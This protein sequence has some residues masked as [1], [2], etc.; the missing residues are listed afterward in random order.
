MP[1]KFNPFTGNLDIEGPVLTGSGTVSA[2]ADGTEQ[3]PGISFANDLDTGIYRPGANQLAISTGGTAR[4]FVDSSGNIKIGGT[5]PSSQNISLNAD[6]S[7]E[8]SGS[9]SIGGT[10]AANTIDEYE[11]GTFSPDLKV[12]TSNA[13]LTGN[14]ARGS[15]TRIGNI[16]H[17]QITLIIDST[18]V[19]G[20]TGGL[21]IT[22]LPFASP[23]NLYSLYNVGYVGIFNWA[24]D[25]RNGS[26][27][28][29]GTNSNNS[30]EISLYNGSRSN[31]QLDETA[32]DFVPGKNQIY[33]NM[34][35]RV[36]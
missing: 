15:Y 1:Y 32:L 12:G 13:G 4:L 33:V 10:A 14:N 17:I 27:T 31:G 9:V 3:V 2:A 35:Y 34:T 8:F 20:L 6:G 19:T 23:N 28:I 30:T 16:A 18:D 11:E 29:Y 7:T 21:S 24:T 25:Y 26:K 22:G 36:V 5:L